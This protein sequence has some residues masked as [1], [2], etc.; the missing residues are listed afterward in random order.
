MTIF[1]R[2]VI[3]GMALL[4]SQLPLFVE[5]YDIRLQAHISE[6]KR[7]VLQ[8]EEVAK[9]RNKS[10]DEYIG[11]FISSSDQDIE[12]QGTFMRNLVDR[13]HQLQLYHQRLLSQTPL[14]RPVIFFISCE[15]TIAMET[16]TGFKAGFIMTEVGVIWLLLG[17][18][19]GYFLVILWRKRGSKKT[20]A[21]EH[22]ENLYYEKPCP[23][24]A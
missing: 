20:K 6:A 19:F 24:K 9:G 15:S 5:Q 8:L 22:Q 18:L 7:T 17:A 10:L 21:S 12:A 4:L 23:P 3:F 1:E 11:K 13:Y 16:A 14:L 2:I